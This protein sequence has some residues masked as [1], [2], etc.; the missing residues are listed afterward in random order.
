MSLRAKCHVFYLHMPLRAKCHV[1]YLNMPICAKC[2]VFYLH[3]PSRL[4]YHYKVVINN[5][6]PVRSRVKKEEKSTMADSFANQSRRIKICCK[7]L[8][9]KEISSDERD[10]SVFKMNECS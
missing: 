4:L 10:S 6:L 3:M 1:F 7:K 8:K 2:H 5:L 9:E